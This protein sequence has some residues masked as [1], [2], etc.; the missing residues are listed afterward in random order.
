MY[1]LR[2]LGI[3]KIKYENRAESSTNSRKALLPR[4]PVSDCL[5]LF[6]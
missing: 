4:I 2:F 6:P 5:P 1:I 3:P